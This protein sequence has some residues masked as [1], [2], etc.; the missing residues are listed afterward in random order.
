[1][2]D[3]YRLSHFVF[4]SLVEDREELAIDCE[5]T[6]GGRYVLVRVAVA[7]NDRERVIGKGGRTL[8]LIKTILGLAAKN[9]GQTVELNLY[10]EESGSSSPRKSR[11][12]RH[13]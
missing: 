3:F 1:M 9:S 8:N 2:V 7:D 12:S 13:R 4:A 11:R 6:G 10:T 5:T